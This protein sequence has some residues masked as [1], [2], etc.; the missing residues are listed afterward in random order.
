MYNPSTVKFYPGRAA[1]PRIEEHW[2]LPGR[3]SQIYSEARSAVESELLIIV[4]IAIRALLEA[5]CKEVKA[6]GRDLYKK[7]DDLHVKSLVT[8]E[9][10]ETL[11]KV[12]LLGNRA[13]HESEAH[14]QGQLLLAL[15]VVEHILVGTYIIPAK[16][17]TVFKSLTETEPKMLA[18]PPPLP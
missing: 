18:P 1:G 17:R 15:E 8:K 9:G 14:S 2:Y 7:I 3:I 10:V 11:Q 12:R 13:A 4:G 6:T 5:I 16:V